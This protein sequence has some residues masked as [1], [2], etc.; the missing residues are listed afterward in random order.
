MNAFGIALVWC[1][2]QVTLIG[3]L[4]AGLYLVV[5]QLRPAA[6]VSV[7]LTGL[8]VV[9][10]LSLMIASPWPRWTISHGSPHPLEKG[11]GVR[12][13]QRDNTSLQTDK[14]DEPIFGDDKPATAKSTPSAG[15]L[16]WQSISDELAPPQT[17]VSSNTRRWPSIVAVLF[18]AA[19]ALG[20]A[21]LLLG[22]MA[23]RRER[24]R[25]RPVSDRELL[26]LVDVL[27]AELGCCREIEIRQSDDLA[28]AATVGWRRPV[29]LLPTDWTT[30]TA[31]QRRAILAHE[32]AHVRGHDFLALFFGQLGLVLHFYHPLLHWLMNRLRL[33]QELAAD[34]A[35]A[36]ISGGQRKYLTTIAE[37]ALQQQDRPLSWH[38]SAFLPTQTTFLRRIAMLRSSTGR[39]NQVSP[40][41]KW[42][43]VSIVLFC[44]LLASGLRAPAQQP[45]PS[46]NEPGKAKHNSFLEEQTREAEA[47]NYWAKY[48]LWAAYHKGGVGVSKNP[49]KAKQLL[50]ELVDGAY[51]ATFKPVNEFKPT[52][53]SE[54]LQE[55]GKHSKLQSEAKGLG[56]ASFFRTR[57]KNGILI[58]SFITAYPDK[59]RE[60]IANNPSLKL[61]SIEKMTP[62]MFVRHD[63]SRQES[64]ASAEEEEK[65][66][67]GGETGA[68]TVDAAAGELKYDDG[69][70]DGKRSF[71]GSGEIIQFS[72]PTEQGKI[73]GIR[74][75]GSRYGMPE[76]PAEDFVI[77]GLSEDMSDVLFTETAPYKLFERGQERWVDVQFKKVREV[78]KT[79]WIVVDFKAHQTKGV[80]VSYDTSTGGKHSKVGLPGQDAAAVNFGGDW[81]IRVKLADKDVQPTK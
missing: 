13:A 71:G 30:W 23:V 8:T 33:E 50:A 66:G 65:L 36:G 78:P 4:A 16:L 79:F 42:T 60:A 74:I 77:Y 1:V 11:P 15:A 51:L 12:I 38:A 54:F 59:M 61:I 53:P 28:T 67:V 57:A 70:P 41:T 2:L 35:A 56:G 25:C 27:C 26:E 7:A 20:L 64:L 22:V 52:N 68:P 10:V 46:D 14:D 48:R 73:T 47:G 62:E 55:F 31:D 40:I 19:M 37:L 45:K 72:L 58:G 81:M 76:P 21:W 63:A 24:L 3:V 5:R 43:T 6:A 80:Y 69:K 17:P 75:H 39:L 49:D 18:F 9:I 32:I 44:G 34:A 29:L